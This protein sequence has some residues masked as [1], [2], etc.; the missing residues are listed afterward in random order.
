MHILV[1]IF[2]F[3]LALWLVWL[4]Q[5]IP[6]ALFVNLCVPPGDGLQMMQLGGGG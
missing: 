6:L 3:W 1:L 2:Y 4:L 5:L